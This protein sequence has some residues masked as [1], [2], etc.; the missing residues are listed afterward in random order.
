MKAV[1]DLS[2]RPELP[3]D[4]PSV[5]A[6]LRKAFGGEVP[7]ALAKRLRSDGLHVPALTGVAWQGSRLVGSLMISRVQ[8]SVGGA[9]FDALNLTPFAVEPASQGRGI[10]RALMTWALAAAEETPYPLVLLEGDPAHY[11]RYG[12][13]RS[14]EHG[15]A[16]PSERIPEPAFQ[17]RLL[18]AYR[19]DLHRGVAV[20]PSAF[21]ELGAIGP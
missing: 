4:E 19:P 11:A 13:E 1:P 6:L 17:V 18:P 12:F 7:A 2:V 10:G 15:I 14:T 8:V 3:G 5:T 9:S 16:R 21:H 20:Y